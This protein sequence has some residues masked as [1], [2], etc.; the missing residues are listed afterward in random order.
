MKSGPHKNNSA[1]FMDGGGKEKWLTNIL[2][3]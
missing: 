3:K 2:V 1:Y